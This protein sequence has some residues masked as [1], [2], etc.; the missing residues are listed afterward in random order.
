MARSGIQEELGPGVVSKFLCCRKIL[1]GQ[2]I[3]FALWNLAWGAG[4]A[5]GAAGGAGLAQATSD[6]VPYLLLAAA[7]LL[8][9][10]LAR[11]A[12]ARGSYF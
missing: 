9:A 5:V 12:Y 6:A 11:G 10:R 3:A 8:T 2:G 4:Q 1:L 7:C